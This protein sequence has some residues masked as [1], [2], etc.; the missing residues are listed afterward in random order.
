GET[1]TKSGYIPKKHGIV[2]KPSKKML[3]IVDFVY[4]YQSSVNTARKISVSELREGLLEDDEYNRSLVTVPSSR[5]ALKP[6]FASEDYADASD[7]GTANHLFM[8][9]CD[10]DRIDTDGV[11]KEAE[12][13]LNI[14]MI[15]EK[16]KELLNIRSL[17]TFF[18]SNLYSRI[19]NSKKV[20]REKR[21]SVSDVFQ[22]NGEA[23]LVQ[24]VIDCFFENPDGTFTVVDYKTDRVREEAE[25]INR[26]KLQ[27]SC[28]KRA[29]ERMTGREV[30]NVLIYSFSLGKEVAVIV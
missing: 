25:L 16:Q 8:Q 27:L 14:R 23:I 4:P 2:I 28:Y 15:S 10:F 29:V 9:F 21:F 12:R 1:D 7:I 5:V 11:E 30:N 26:H 18:K 13:L 6:A 22:E 17:S 20:Y 24:G 19:R 3:D